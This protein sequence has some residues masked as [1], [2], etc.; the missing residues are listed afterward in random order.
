MDKKK[1]W[2]I[3]SKKIANCTLMRFYVFIEPGPEFTVTFFI[4]HCFINSKHM[5][6]LQIVKNA[7]KYVVHI[8]IIC[9]YTL[10]SA[11]NNWWKFYFIKKKKND[12]AFITVATRFK[13]K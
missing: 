9:F 7:S 5:Y 2:T 6:S 10:F 1:I 4:F 3:R 12:E 8:R 11:I 13:L